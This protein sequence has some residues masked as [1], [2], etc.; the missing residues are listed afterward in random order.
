MS[1]IKQISLLVLALVTVGCIARSG[2]GALD[3]VEKRVWVTGDQERDRVGVLDSD[4][5]TI[6]WV[7]L[8]EQP[9]KIYA[10]LPSPHGRYVAILSNPITYTVSIYTIVSVSDTEWDLQ[11]YT[12]LVGY[13]GA[14]WSPDS[15]ELLLWR[16]YWDSPEIWQASSNKV[17]P[18]ITESGICSATW[19]RDSQQV[20]VSFCMGDRRL[21][22][23]SRSDQT[24][25]L[26]LKFSFQ[27]DE[28]YAVHALI[29][30][31]S[32]D[33]QLLLL[34]LNL[35]DKDMTG[36]EIEP[37]VLLEHKYALFDLENYVYQ[38]IPIT[39]YGYPS[40]HA[41]INAHQLFIVSP[42]TSPTAIHNYKYIVFNAQTGHLEQVLTKDS[43]CMTAVS[44]IPDD[45]NSVLLKYHPCV[46]NSL[47]GMYRLDLVTGKRTR[48]D[49]EYEETL[50]FL[51]MK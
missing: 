23:W 49:I 38:L 39:V 2:T 48:L 3:S 16:S 11:P 22:A 50:S 6:H 36:R 30:G 47:D 24:Q 18:T 33:R 28:R 25:T 15:D 13:A 21:I 46:E 1:C 27:V 17:E 26:L 45:H 35:S 40:Y 19:G 51:M 34:D 32:P 14:Q 5:G 8:P 4:T 20:V 31:R 10:L 43:S 29:S 7:K 42:L 37:P 41:W 12:S 9:G 44:N